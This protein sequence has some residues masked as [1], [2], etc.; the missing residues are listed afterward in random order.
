MLNVRNRL[1]AE[2]KLGTYENYSL[3]G[4]VFGAL[5]FSAGIGLSAISSKGIPVI[6]A[7][8]GAFVVFI[9]SGCFVA[10]LVMKEFSGKREISVE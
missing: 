8:L 5:F 3:A 6:I 7:M 10:V 9:S 1:K 4:V 2:T